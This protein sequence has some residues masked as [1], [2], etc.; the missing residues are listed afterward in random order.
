MTGEG[1]PRVAS[2]WK[3]ADVMGDPP[4]DMTLGEMAQWA[5]PMDAKTGCP[6]AKFTRQEMKK[7]LTFIGFSSDI[8]FQIFLIKKMR[9]NILLKPNGNDRHKKEWC[10]CQALF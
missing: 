2:V 3:F 8:H 4:P 1:C 5:L 10:F 9:R 6:I 7:S